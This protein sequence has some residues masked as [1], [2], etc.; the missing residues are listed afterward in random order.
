M[1][2]GIATRAQ[3]CNTRS[4]TCKVRGLLLKSR[5]LWAGTLI[6]VEGLL[7]KEGLPIDTTGHRAPLAKTIKLV[8]IDVRAPCKE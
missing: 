3:C 2:K 6:K 8:E 1:L 5:N 4:K 7:A